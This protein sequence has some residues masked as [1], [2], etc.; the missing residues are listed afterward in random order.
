[1][2]KIL[3]GIALLFMAGNLFAQEDNFK[4]SC[5]SNSGLSTSTNLLDV[6]A[7]TRVYLKISLDNPSGKTYVG[8]QFDIWLPKGWEVAKNNSG[9]YLTAKL[10]DL[11]TYTNED[12]D[13]INPFDAG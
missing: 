2:K 7:D 10:G 5:Y 6:A 8:T 4:I 13:E 1:M 11:K 3:F 9:N 12:D